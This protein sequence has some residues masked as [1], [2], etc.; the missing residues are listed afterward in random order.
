M[1]VCAKCNQEVPQED[2][3][4]DHGELVCENCKINAIH[5]PSKPCGGEK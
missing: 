3:Y 1:A 5:S 2:L 4:E